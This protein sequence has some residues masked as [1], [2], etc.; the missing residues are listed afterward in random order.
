MVLP[1]QVE[2]FQKINTIKQYFYCRQSS[3]FDERIKI[4][5]ELTFFVD[6]SFF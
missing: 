2:S 5:D 4:A 1:G 6:K 3:I